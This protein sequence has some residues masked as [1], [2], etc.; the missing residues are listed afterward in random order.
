MAQLEP[1]LELQWNMPT[2]STTRLASRSIVTGADL[3]SRTQRPPSEDL[4]WRLGP[5]CSPRIASALPSGESGRQAGRPC[6]PSPTRAREAAMWTH[7]VVTGLPSPQQ[8]EGAVHTAQ[9][10]SPPGRGRD[11]HAPPRDLGL[12]A[13]PKSG[14]AGVRLE[15]TATANHPGLSGLMDPNRSARVRRRAAGVP[16]EAGRQP[17]RELRSASAVD[18]PP[19]KRGI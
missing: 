2:L 16:A 8:R 17:P 5:H 6:L 3:G 4:A 10:Q 9:P 19:V 18:S 12:A 14:C 1:T 15:G 11:R 7:A 13:H